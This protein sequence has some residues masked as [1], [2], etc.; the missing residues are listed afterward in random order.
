[1][2]DFTAINLAFYLVQ[3]VDNFGQLFFVISRVIVQALNL[4]LQFR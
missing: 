4:I 3:N 1:M 2:E